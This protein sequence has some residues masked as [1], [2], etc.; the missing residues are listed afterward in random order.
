MMK[1]CNTLVGIVISGAFMTLACSPR[2][3][4][5]V[6]EGSNSSEQSTTDVDV[7][8]IDVP[9]FCQYKNAYDP[10]ATCNNTSLAMVLGFQGK[11]VTP[12]EIYKAVGKSNSLDAIKKAAEHYGFKASAIKNASIASMKEELDAGRPFVLG[13][14]FTGAVGHYITVTGYDSTGFFVSDPAGWWDE[15][16]FSPASG[17]GS[18]GKCPRATGEDRHYSFSAMKKANGMHGKGGDGDFWVVF[19]QK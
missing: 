15:V 13:G 10:G 2:N 1:I 19:V 8:R 16:S 17:Y 9:Y 11:K 4:N 14:Y 5:K 7:K 12:D 3:F 18:R 6:I